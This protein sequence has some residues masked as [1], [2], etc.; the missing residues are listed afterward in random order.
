VA[1][2]A[3]PNPS[4]VYYAL[5]ASEE[6]W[7][8]FHQ[9]GTVFGAINKTDLSNAPLPWPNRETVQKL[10]M[11]LTVIDRKIRSLSIEIEKLA[12]LRDALLPDLVSG[13]IRVPE[14]TEATGAA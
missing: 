8:P 5:R 3:S 11:T 9:E 7:S 4:T 2:V 1:A 12:S 14:A 6:T 10:E 13:R